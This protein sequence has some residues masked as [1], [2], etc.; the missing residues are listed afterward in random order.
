M[1]HKGLIF[2]V[3]MLIA[4]SVTL[5][6]QDGTSPPADFKEFWELKKWTVILG[7]LLALIGLLKNTGLD[8]KLEKY[9]IGRLL[10]STINLALSFV[11]KKYI[12]YKLKKREL[13]ASRAGGVIKVLLIGLFLSSVGLSVAAQDGILK[14]L[15]DP[16]TKERIVQKSQTFTGESVE[17]SAWFP[18]GAVTITGVKFHHNSDEGKFVTEEFTRAGAG[19]EFAHFRV[20]NDEVIN[21]YGVGGYF[22]PPLSTDPLQ[23]YASVMIAGSIYDLGYRFKLEFLNGVGV[24]LGFCYDLNKTVPAKDNFSFV[25]NFKITF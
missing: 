13:K 23:Q 5:L 12:A 15:I 20:L 6:G 10:L 3:M 7:G 9:W 2:M 1:K 14:K 17:E 24:G 22:M 16:V 25:P 8:Q 21:D 11:G 19:I 4:F 18:R